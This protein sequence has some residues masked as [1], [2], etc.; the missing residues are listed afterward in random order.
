MSRPE[1]A[2]IRS[3]PAAGVKTKATTDSSARCLDFPDRPTTPHE[4]RKYRKSFFDEPGQRVIHYG[5]IDDVKGMDYSRACGKTTTH[6]DHVPDVLAHGP[7]TTMQEYLNDRKESIYRSVRTEPLGKSFQRGTELKNGCD[8]INFAFGVGSNKSD[9]AKTMIYPQTNDDED[10]AHAQYVKSHNSY[11]AGEQRKRDYSWKEF[12]VD[13][14]THV[15][16]KVDK[17]KII[18]GVASCV[19][20][21]NSQPTSMIIPKQVEDYRSMSADVLGKCKNLGQAANRNL[22]ADHAFGFV[23]KKQDISAAEAIMGSYSY[24]EQLPDKDLGKSIT[25]GWRN[26]PDPQGPGDA[27]RAFGC[28]TLRTDIAAP[29]VR[30]VGDNQNYGD[31]TNAKALL[32]PSQ[33]SGLGVDDDD[34]LAKRPAEEIKSIFQSIVPGLSDGDFDKLYNRAQAVYGRVTVDSFRL[35]LN[36]VD[37]SVHNTGSHPSWW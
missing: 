10:D 21:D 16:G 7:Q 37:D 5:L 6:S 33:Y 35:A 28:P 3:V 32:H 23:K 34:F 13:P 31:D 20:P 14:N 24:G 9:S 30:S 36:E 26:I 29:K 19:Q 17:N 27:D 1:P 12:G 2:Y 25:P 15:F 8:D 22:P 18:G 11:Y 4:V